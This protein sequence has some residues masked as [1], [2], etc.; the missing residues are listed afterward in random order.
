M[1][2]YLAFVSLLF[3]GI[4][5]A[6]GFDQ[7]KEYV[8]VYL[9]DKPPISHEQLTQ[10]Y[11]PLA[12]ERR[13]RQQ[14]QFDEYDY[15]INQNYART[16]LQ[17]G[18][19]V[20]DY[21]DWLNAVLIA[22]SK[23]SDKLIDL[24][25]YEFV[26]DYQ[27]LGGKYKVEQYAAPVSDAR[28]A[29]VELMYAELKQTIGLD[30]LHELGYLGKGIQVAIIDAG[31]LGVDT[32]EV[33]RF[34]RDQ[35]Q[36]IYTHNFV[37]STQ[38]VYVD[39]YHGAKVLS[40]LSSSINEKVIGGAPESDFWL[41]KTEDYF[42]EHPI[43]EFYY[44]K[45]LEFCDKAG[46]DIIN[47][48]IGYNRFDESSYNYLNSDLYTSCSIST[49]ASEL[50]ASRGMLIV[51]SAGNEG[52]LRWKEVTIP[53]DAKDIIAVGVT[54]IAGKP[55]SYASYGR[56]ETDIKR[57]NLS[58]P[59]HKVYTVNSSGSFSLSF[60]S[61]YAAPLITAAAACLWQMKPQLNVMELIRL[62]EQSAK[63]YHKPQLK[64]GYGLPDIKQLLRGLRQE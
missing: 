61:S 56:A 24:L 8:I 43:E 44:I 1:R 58:A 34:L 52:N 12:L 30:T 57:P 10:A 38:S 40:L 54:N 3:L 26:V 42:N 31:F 7:D 59:G 41:L 33:F 13:K 29:E 32:F 27:F 22:V 53:A 6:H 14:L 20:L 45:A 63:D 47:A 55:T 50:A 39:S 37:D 51:T 35:N 17:D 19:Q 16:L 23:E 46:I 4:T 5:Q 9:K 21:S 11:S 62:L 28:I 64:T 49:K 25:S 36:I 15:P 18:Y 48:S 2:L 60:G